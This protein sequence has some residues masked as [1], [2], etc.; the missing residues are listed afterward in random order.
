[1][2]VNYR[3]TALVPNVYKIL[4]KVVETQLSNFL[5]NTK[6]IADNQFGF[7]RNRGTGEAIVLSLI[8]I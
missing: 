4:E 5:E 3:P 1:M 6:F 2:E 8:H 7:G